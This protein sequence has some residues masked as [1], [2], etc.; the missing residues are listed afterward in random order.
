MTRE[1]R[2]P[3]RWPALSSSKQSG[4]GPHLHA[5]DGT[6]L[7]NG[8]TIYGDLSSTDTQRLAETVMRFIAWG[9]RPGVVDVTVSK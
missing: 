5:Q 3:L 9:E 6:V 4:L 8:I 7:P 1:Y 2:D